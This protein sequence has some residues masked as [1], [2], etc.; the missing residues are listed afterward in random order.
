MSRVR[1]SHCSFR[2]SAGRTAA[3]DFE[4]QQLPTE[5]ASPNTKALVVDDNE[6]N[7]T[8]AL[9]FL[10]HHGIVSD[11]ASSGAE[12]LK[13]AVE[14]DYDIIFMDHIMPEMDGLEATKRLRETSTAHNRNVPVIALAANAVSGMSEI[15]TQ[16]GMNDFLAKPLNADEL[17]VILIHWLPPEKIMI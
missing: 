8:V 17:N 2:S 10:D 4:T 6:I 11:V 13:M 12:A 16:N 15:F 5:K 3:Y 9:A 14:T 1:R 7:Q